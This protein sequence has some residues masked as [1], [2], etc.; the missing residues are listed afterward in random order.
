[1]IFQ[2][3]EA[4]LPAMEHTAFGSES[5]TEL[6]AGASG[7]LLSNPWSPERSR[8]YYFF[9]PSQFSSRISVTQCCSAENY[10]P[11]PPASSRLLHSPHRQSS[12]SP[13]GMHLA[14]CRLPWH[15][16]LYPSSL[17]I[18]CC[19]SGSV[20][21]PRSHLDNRHPLCSGIR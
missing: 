5:K 1:M 4:Q 10:T 21:I 9:Y 16:I 6:P 11:Y 19:L 20:S 7:L 14:A 2:V 12:P 15:I 8:Y 18:S 3:L 17:L 13:V